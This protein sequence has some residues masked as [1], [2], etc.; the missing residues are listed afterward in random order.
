MSVAAPLPASQLIEYATDVRSR[1]LELVSDLSDEQWLGPQ[2]AIV[3]PIRWEIGHM[4]WFQEYWLLRHYRQKPP[5][6]D[7]ADSLYDSSNVHHDTRW[8][9]KLPSRQG[10]LDY[11]QRVLDDVVDVLQK[12]EPDEGATYFSLLSTLHEDMHTEALTYT[13][14][15]H[16]YTAPS[17]KVDFTPSY[18]QG[19]ALPGDVHIP[20]GTFMMGSTSDVPF[21]F[22]NEKWA[23]PVEVQPFDMAR[24][25]VTNNEFAAF[26]EDRGYERADLWTSEGWAWRQQAGATHPVY[27]RYDGEWQRR[28]FDQWVP[29]EPHHP[30]IHVNWYEAD[31]YCRWAGRRLPTEAEWEMA[32]SCEPS[33]DGSGMT[34][35]RRRY[36]WGDTAPT[37]DLANLGWRAMGCIPVDALPESDSAFGCRQM[38]GNVWEWTSTDFGP[39]PEFAP[40]PYKDYSQPWFTGHKVHRGG[41]WTTRMRLIH[42]SWRNFYPPHRRDVWLGFRT[43]AQSA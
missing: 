8:D 15:T 9:L 36:P 43:C 27:W 28:S 3:N 10:T 42:N 14:Q 22:D 34:S 38:L 21:V 20:G 4:A 6:R 41:C 37:P 18:G 13:R 12:R 25:P 17:L 30:I 33:P 26:V 23:H 32:A 31:A 35:R 1:T 39:Y 19:N 16:A 5:I 7:D 40:D 24:A 2:L 11:M 29:L